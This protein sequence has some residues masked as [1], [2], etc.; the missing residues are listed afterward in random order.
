MKTDYSSPELKE[1][2]DLF[3]FNHEGVVNVE[4]T[5]ESLKRL[6]YDKKY[7]TIY[8]VVESF[9]EGDLTYEDFAEKFT[10]ALTDPHG[11]VG[12]QR[13]FDLFIN[14]PKKKSIDLDG[15]K[16]ICKELGEILTDKDA[17]FIMNEVGDGES[18]S[19]DEFKEFMNKKYA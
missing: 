6:D 11:D 12:V 10:Y 9:G 17:E 16:K 3:D 8:E 18:I 13:L 1:A 5:L 4:E 2:F 14:D 19:F 15:L 7:P